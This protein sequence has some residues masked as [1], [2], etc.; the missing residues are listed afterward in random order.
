M[1]VNN[2]LGC[3]VTK[4]YKYFQI[5]SPRLYFTVKLLL[6]G[7]QK[8]YLNE[9]LISCFVIIFFHLILLYKPIFNVSTRHHYVVK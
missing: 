9:F 1:S 3:I 6:E 7:I 4:D 8:N 5:V 2:V